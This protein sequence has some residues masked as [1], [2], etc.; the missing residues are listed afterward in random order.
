[1]RKLHYLAMWVS[2]MSMEYVN[3]VVPTP[4]YNV[5]MFVYCS[6]IQANTH[7]IGWSSTPNTIYK[8]HCSSRQ[9]SHETLFILVLIIE[10][11]I[12][13]NTISKEHTMF[14]YP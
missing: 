3:Y 9:Y 13:S 12:Q 1:M 4:L 14:T 8:N 6:Y 7:K 5:R 11:T 10:Y 2:S